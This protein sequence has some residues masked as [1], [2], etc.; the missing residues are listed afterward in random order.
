MRYLVCVIAA[1]L[2]L[3][4]H[5]AGT[6]RAASGAALRPLVELYTS[7]GCSSCPPADRWLSRAF[8]TGDANS[9]IPLAFHVD[10]WDRLGWKDRFASAS[11]TAR[12][13]QVMR[14]NRATFVYTPQVVL[15]GRDFTAWRRGDSGSALATAAARRPRA[16]LDIA[17]SG[18]ADGVAAQVRVSL[19]EAPTA[20]TVLSLAYVESG[21][22]S[23]VEAGENRGER[24]RHDHVVRALAS[25]DLVA[26][27]SAVELRLPR[28]ADPGQRPTLVAFAQDV[29]TGE[30]LQSVSVALEG[31][32]AR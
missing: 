32:D 14:A 12:Q 16:S 3:P 11:F 23:E 29:A 1:T 15:Q 19:T 27:D 10:Y 26:R 28:P 30:V 24:L 2:A 5:A 7:E 22:E 9:A 18:R 4:T 21:L 20:S 31:C 6:C 13:Y 8:P 17:A 25:R